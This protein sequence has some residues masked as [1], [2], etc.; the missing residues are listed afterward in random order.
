MVAPWCDGDG[1]V[2]LWPQCFLRGGEVC[3][4]GGEGGPVRDRSGV[5]P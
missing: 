2:A 4:M 1:D 3:C 5:R